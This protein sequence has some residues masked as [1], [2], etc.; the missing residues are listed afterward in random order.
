MLARSSIPGS[1][2]LYELR[3]SLFACLDINEPTT[4]FDLW[5]PAVDRVSSAIR[6]LELS[7]TPADADALAQLVAAFRVEAIRRGKPRFVSSPSYPWRV[8][9]YVDKLVEFFRVP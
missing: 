1:A 8:T 2:S 6:T 4:R 9:T 5:K 3:A 7:A